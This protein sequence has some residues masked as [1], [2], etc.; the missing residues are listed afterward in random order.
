MKQKYVIG[1]ALLLLLLLGVATTSFY[2]NAHAAKKSDGGGGSQAAAGGGET[3][4]K[5]NNNNSTDQLLAANVPAPDGVIVSENLNKP[6]T[7]YAG[8]ALPTGDIYES[9]ATTAEEVNLPVVA[10]GNMD[11]VAVIKPT[12]Y[13]GYRTT[14]SAV[15]SNKKHHHIRMP[16]NLGIEI[17]Y[18]QSKLVSNQTNNIPVGNVNFGLLYNLSLGDNFAFQPG[19]RY[20]TRG[21][22]LQNEM[23]IDNKEKLVTHYFEMPLNLVCKMGKIGNARIMVGAGPYIAYLASTKHKFQ[24][25]TFSD[26]A[27]AQPETPQYNTNSINRLDAGIGGFIGCQSPDGFFIKAGGEYGMKNLMKDAN[28]SATD[29]NYSLMVNIGFIMGNKL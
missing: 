25:S 11:T 3:L 20:I 12:V 7:K 19:I 13:Y 24:S 9:P 5:A 22:R 4:L 27:D 23:D 6:R 16:Q 17:G 1:S 26:V 8:A 2:L 29:R 18:N 28:G 15:K 14:N 10:P 21:N